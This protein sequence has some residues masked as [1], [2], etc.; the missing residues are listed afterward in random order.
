MTSVP[1]LDVADTDMDIQVNY[2]SKNGESTI[3]CY[4]VYDDAETEKLLQK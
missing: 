3:A 2:K 4:P 1:G